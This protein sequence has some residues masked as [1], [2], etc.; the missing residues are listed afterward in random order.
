MERQVKI[1]N[2]EGFHARPAGV[3]VKKASEFQANI[4]VMANGLTK[5]AKSIMSIMSL[6]LEK[7]SEMTIVAKGDDE[8]AALDA[9]EK[10]VN[11]KFVLE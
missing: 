11:S 8:S 5:N 4:E 6:G 9:L 7:G 10:L 1:L 3:F 2:E